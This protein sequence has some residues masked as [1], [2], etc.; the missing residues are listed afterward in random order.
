MPPDVT[1]T[2]AQEADR[3]SLRCPIWKLL[4]IARYLRRPTFISI[5]YLGKNGVFH[6]VT[7]H[8]L[9]RNGNSSQRYC[10]LYPW[11]ASWAVFV[12]PYPKNSRRSGKSG[13]RLSRVPNGRYASR[14]RQ[15]QIY[16][17]NIKRAVF[18]FQLLAGTPHLHHVVILKLVEGGL[19]R[20]YFFPGKNQQKEYS[21]ALLVPVAK[22]YCR[23][24]TYLCPF[25]QNGPPRKTCKPI[26]Y[27]LQNV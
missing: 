22:L 17:S 5:P 10:F 8:A 4:L 18:D 23:W 3:F 20:L 7:R 11:Q 9:N 25:K 6:H 26:N 1:Y 19:N 12:T 13:R 16:W 15:L 21:R 14:D 27:T 24:P 2:L